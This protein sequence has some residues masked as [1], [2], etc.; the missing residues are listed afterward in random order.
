MTRH[1]YFALWSLLATAFAIIATYSCFDPIKTGAVEIRTSTI[2]QSLTKDHRPQPATADTLAI[3][4][5]TAQATPAPTDTTAQTILIIGDSMLE[6]INPRL[7]AY[8]RAAGHTLHSV[9]WYSS[10]TEYWG[11]CDTLSVFMRRYHP[12]FVF[13]SLGANELFV[14]DIQA[15]RTPYL[16]NILSQL[17]NTPYL[18]IG[19]PNWRDDTGINRMIEANTPPGC[20][21]KSQGM[22]FDRAKDGAHPTHAS[23]AQWV[24]SIARWIPLHS[25]HPI[26]MPHPD[27][28]KARPASVTVLAPKK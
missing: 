18:W 6:G 21:F 17:G 19:P 22:H 27:Q 13:I 5:P 7:A 2:A 4:A 3:P 16:R 24:D 11:T 10:T 15:K 23:A 8:A 25:A 12:T 14:R 28:A 26:L 20:Y 9:I 1:P